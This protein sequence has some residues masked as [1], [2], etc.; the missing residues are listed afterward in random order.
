[1]QSATPNKHLNFYLARMEA[2]RLK[3]GQVLEATGLTAAAVADG[4][5]ATPEQYRK[6][7]RNIIRLTGDPFVGIALGAEFK[8]S[9]LGILGYAALS[10]SSLEQSRELFT[11]YRALNERLFTSTNAIRDGRWFSE[12]T[13]TYMLGDLLRFAIEE[14]VS[15]TMALA[16]ALTGRPFPVLEIFVTYPRPGDITLYERRF[17]CPLHFG[18]PRNLIL[19][20]VERL[21]DPISL[22]NEEVF[23]LCE[24][25]CQLLVSE[26]EGRELLS[27]RIRNYLVRNPGVFP[28]LEDMAKRFSIG[29]RTLRR[30]LVA[31]NVAYQQILDETRRKLAIQ[32][33]EQTTLTPKEIGFLL[34]YSSV[35]NFRRAFKCWTGKKLS[36]FRS[37]AETDD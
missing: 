22:A 37:G 34:G 12:I 30:R 11:R 5:E 9:D 1:M 16:E 27:N 10:A 3:A 29:A 36:D 35:S 33:L 23:R 21:R 25:R 19:F 24:H 28:T 17:N 4:A 7:I 2:R 6:V 18:Q 20:D 32:Y 31:E 26:K 8:I 15:Q 13:D 14:F